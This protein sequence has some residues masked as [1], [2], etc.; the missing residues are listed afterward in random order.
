MVHPDGRL[1]GLPP[2]HS[3]RTVINP[4]H[5]F[6]KN[7]GTYRGHSER[8]W[9]A[10]VQLEA[11]NIEGIDVAVL[12]PTRG[13]NVLSE[14]HMEP[15]FAAALARAYN[16]W[17]Y[18]FARRIPTGCSAPACFRPSTWTTRSRRLGVASR[19]SAFAPCSALQHHERPQLA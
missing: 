1:W 5:N 19:S 9:N 18:D 15:A 17:L 7:Q 14:P 2:R 16:N 4:G 11:M 10:E 6:Q 8:G 12:F 3:E 13:L